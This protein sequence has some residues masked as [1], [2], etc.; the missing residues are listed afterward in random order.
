MPATDATESCSDTSPSSSGARATSTITAAA[1]VGPG[2]TGR[3]TSSAPRA[4]ASITT[5]R[6]VAIASPVSSA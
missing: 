6:K 3:P 4:T 1:M 5:D 2:V